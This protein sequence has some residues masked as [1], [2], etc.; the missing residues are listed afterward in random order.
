M[1]AVL[2]LAALL[3]GAQFQVHWDGNRLH[4]A[5]QQ[6]HGSSS[7]CAVFIRATVDR[8]HDFIATHCARQSLPFSKIVE[9]VIADLEASPS[10]RILPADQLI[11]KSIGNMAGCRLANA[12]GFVDETRFEG[13]LGSAL[14]R[15]GG[16]EAHF[17]K[18]I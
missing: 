8:Y 7:D 6:A 16:Y 13:T 1:V 9:S 12:S 11:L 5:C 3:S 14:V 4:A 17:R 2:L 18:D 15:E 10:T